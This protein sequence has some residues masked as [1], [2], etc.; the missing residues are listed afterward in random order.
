MPVDREIYIEESHGF[1]KDTFPQWQCPSCKKSVL[2]VK[3]FE[4]THDG[5]TEIY[6]SEIWFEPIDDAHLRYTALLSCTNPKCQENVV[7]V[8]DGYVDY[9]YFDGPNGQDRRYQKYYNPLYCYPTIEF[10]TIPDDT[11][12]KVKNALLDSFSIAYTN[13]DSAVNKCRIALECLLKDLDL[14]QVDKYGNIRL[15]E[16]IKSLPAEFKDIQDHLMAIKWLGN[17]GSHCDDAFT[18]HEL[19]DTYD[20]L[21]YVLN[22][23]YE[24]HNKFVQSITDRVNKD[25]R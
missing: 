9:E 22:K 5:G 2:V 12:D 7:N 25:K 20:V 6:S 15:N 14:T 3:N 13:H 4:S 8:G 11:P 23:L 16:S 24:K 17:S 1:T 10:F 21:E 18:L 19:F